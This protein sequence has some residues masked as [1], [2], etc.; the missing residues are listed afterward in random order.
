MLLRMFDHIIELNIWNTK[1][2]VSTKARFDRPKAFYLPR[3]RG[4]EEIDLDFIK[5]LLMQEDNGNH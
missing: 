5:K 3:I 1:E 2:K 4:S